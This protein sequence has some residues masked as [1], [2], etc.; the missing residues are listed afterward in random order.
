[1]D[2]SGSMR[3]QPI[4]ELNAGIN[5][6]KEDLMA[7][8][9]ASKRVEV[10]IVTFG[11]V[12]IEQEFVTADAFIP[13]NLDARGDTP[14]GSAIT[15]GLELLH[16]RKDTYRN[17]GISFYRPWVF[18]IT[19]GGPTDEWHTAAQQVKSGE[20]SK[21]FAFFAVGVEGA[22]FDVLAQIAVREP[23]KLQGLNFRSLFQWLSNS[24][25]AVSRSTPGTEVPLQNP[26]A[27]G[28][29]AEV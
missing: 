18:M 26:T 7:D 21:S 17:N 28:G 6:F 14:M 24:M 22:K 20:E 29:W 9:L 15:Q 11:P 23:L 8:A 1:L 25:K 5:A 27:P 10:A 19:D 3:G 12:N 16:R 2:I 4:K 13:R